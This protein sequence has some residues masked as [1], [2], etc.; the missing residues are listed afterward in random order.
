MKAVEVGECHAMCDVCELCNYNTGN[1]YCRFDAKR[2]CSV[3]FE[4]VEE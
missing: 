2:G 4:E 1:R 3:K